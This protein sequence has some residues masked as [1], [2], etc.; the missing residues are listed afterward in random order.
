MS[1]NK[2]RAFSG[3]TVDKS[4]KFY[5]SIIFCR[6]YRKGAFLFKKKAKNHPN[7]FNSSPVVAL[8]SLSVS[9]S[10][11]Q[12]LSSKITPHLP[13]FSTP[14]RLFPL[15]NHICRSL[16]AFS[17]FN[18]PTIDCI[19]LHFFSPLQFSSLLFFSN[20]YGFEFV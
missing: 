6:W 9:L 2:L 18:S 19:L 20:F 12:S 8:S 16:I 17:F 1:H 5:P 14:S 10:H 3:A 13:S 11:H 4:H 7:K 15:S